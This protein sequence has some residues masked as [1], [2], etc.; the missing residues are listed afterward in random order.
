MSR[1]VLLF[2]CCVSILVPS[3]SPQKATIEAMQVTRGTILAFHVQTR[4]RPSGTSLDG[5]PK[6]TVLFVRVADPID[7]GVDR[8]GTV[9]HGSIASAVTAGSE[10]VIHSDA[11]VRL[12]LVLLRSSSRPEGFRYELLVT[13]LTDHGK[14]M[15]VTA[16]LNPSLFD[17]PAGPHSGM[18]AGSK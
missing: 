2:V 14:A 17:S 8:D 11:E 3:A 18:P 15:E 16:S 9:F 5:L 12:L 1:S 10:T 13:G 4:L 6:G 7:S